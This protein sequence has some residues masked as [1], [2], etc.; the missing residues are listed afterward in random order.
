MEVTNVNNAIVS[1]PQYA[2][3]ATT[4]TPVPK[5]SEPEQQAASGV[6]SNEAAV[7]EP[8]SQSEERPKVNAADIRR[9]IDETNR[10]TESLRE[11][12]LKMFNNQAEKNGLANGTAPFLNPGEMIDIDP[13]TRAKAQED[14][15]EGG[16]YSVE[17]TGDRIF[18]FALAVAGDDP[19]KLEQMRKATEAGFKQAEQQ[20][21]GK[22]P[23]ISYETMEYVRNLFDEK[24]K[25]LGAK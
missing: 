7:Y 20:W 23:P 17:N 10:Q 5:A 6:Q 14:I 16:Y 12:I 2:T 13:E 19:A 8:S 24:L 9:M 15:A 18:N 11:L 25:E 22:L 3:P 21:G 1:N 4:A